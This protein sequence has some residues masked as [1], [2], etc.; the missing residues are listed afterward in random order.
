MFL[1]SC[2]KLVL[3]YYW[4]KLPIKTIGDTI[5]YKIIV[6]KLIEILFYDLVEDN[7]GSLT[8]YRLLRD[9]VILIGLFHLIE[10][11]GWF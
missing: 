5:V 3:G 2:C 9:I 1:S 7:G 4:P 6:A 10:K 8:V 11:H